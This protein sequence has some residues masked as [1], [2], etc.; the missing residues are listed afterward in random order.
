MWKKVQVVHYV[1]VMCRVCLLVDFQRRK[2]SKSD[3]TLR[4]CD[5]LNRVYLYSPLH[6]KLNNFSLEVFQES[7]NYCEMNLVCVALNFDMMLFKVVLCFEILTSELFYSWCGLV[8]CRLNVFCFVAVRRTFLTPSLF[9]SG[10]MQLSPPAVKLQYT[11][12]V[13]L[14]QPWFGSI[15]YSPENRETR[16]IISFMFCWYFQMRLI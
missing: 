2:P 13:S 8:G 5:I 6:V 7:V 9:L 4:Q 15:Q 1:I 16:A 10:K 11:L 14:E 3:M 12:K